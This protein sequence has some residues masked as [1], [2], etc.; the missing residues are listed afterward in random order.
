M[1]FPKKL[2]WNMIF[3]A[4][5]GKIFLFLENMI[6]FFRRK[7]KDD[8]FHKRKKKEK[9]IFS[10]NVLKKWSSQNNCTGI[11]SFLCHQERWYFFFPK[12]W[13][14]SSLDRKWK[15]NLFQIHGNIFSVYSEKRYSFFLYIWYHSSVKKVQMV[16]SRKMYLNMTFPVSL[17]KVI[18]I[19]ESMVFLLM[20]K[21]KMIKK[22]IQSS[23]PR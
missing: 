11:W 10:A 6:L 3:P 9:M 14:Y 4:L 7:M 21:L 18:F 17:K 22:F 23:M 20:E 13:Y 19:L 12:I 15:I 8:L 1:V 5:T 16:F 2:H